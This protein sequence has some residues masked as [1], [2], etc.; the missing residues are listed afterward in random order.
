MPVYR[1]KTIPT[2]TEAVRSEA[3]RGGAGVASELGSADSRE[4]RDG[5]YIK[6]KDEGG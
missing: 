1:T 2:K 4:M 6:M 3:R 5:G